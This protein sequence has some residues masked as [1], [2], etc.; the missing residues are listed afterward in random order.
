MSYQGKKNIPRITVSRARG[1][2]S[3]KGEGCAGIKPFVCAQGDGRGRGG[4]IRSAAN[5]ALPVLRRGGT[6]R[7]GPRDAARGADFTRIA[8]GAQTPRRVSPAARSIAES[9]ASGRGCAGTDPP[10]CPSPEGGCGRRAAL[11]MERALLVFPEKLLARGAFR[12]A[13]RCGPGG[14]GQEPLCKRLPGAAGCG[15]RGLREPRQGR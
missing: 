7:G 13:A 14:D 15:R 2:R 10:A 9:G 3:G 6:R 12:C 11:G 8:R 1:P 5:A 4:I